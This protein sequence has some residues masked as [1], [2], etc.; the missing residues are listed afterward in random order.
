MTEKRIC[1]ARRPNG[2]LCQ[3]TPVAGKRRCKFHGGKSTGSR[4]PEGKAATMAGMQAGVERWREK[5]RAQ[6]AAGLIDRFPGGKR[7]AGQ[8]PAAR[9]GDRDIDRARAVIRETEPDRP[10][11]A[12]ERPNLGLPLVPLVPWSDQSPSEKLAT[13]TDMSLDKIRAIVS[14][15]LDTENMKLMSV[16]KDAAISMLT[17]Q[18]RVDENCLRARRTD[19]LPE[20]LRRLAAAEK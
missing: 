18:T 3:A 1:G 5:V 13:L 6:I 2:S 17:V 8:A 11:E 10:R 15:P 9:S 7:K 14:L 19:M 16:Q 20:L 4:T 12:G